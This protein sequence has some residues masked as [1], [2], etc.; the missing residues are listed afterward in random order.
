MPPLR[1]PVGKWYTA[2]FAWVSSE[3]D[4]RQVHPMA[5]RKHTVI[6][7]LIT[8]FLRLFQSL[9]GA[10][11]WLLVGVIGYFIFKMNN[12]PVNFIIGLPMLFIGIGGVLNSVWSVAMSVFN[13]RYN[14]GV[15]IFCNQ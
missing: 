10:I 6:H 3:F 4:S 13:P 14:R 1:G 5:A 8:A 15:C 9:L 11:V 2:P 7:Y 12:A